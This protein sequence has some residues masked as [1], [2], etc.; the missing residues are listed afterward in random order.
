MSYPECEKAAL[1]R[2]KSQVCGEFLEWLQGEG[3]V[4]AKWQR[5]Q[6]DTLRAASLNMEKTL[7]DFF[8]IDLDKIETE[9]RA[10]LE[11]MRKLNEEDK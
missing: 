3:F 11:D 10:M 8:G 5:G 7:A 9:K 6:Q 2:D 4:I 1:I